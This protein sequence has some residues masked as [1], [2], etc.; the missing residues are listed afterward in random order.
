MSNRDLDEL[1]RELDR[2]MQEQLESLKKRTFGGIGDDEV[3]RE[4]ERLKRIREVS[5]DYLGALKR[6]TEKRRSD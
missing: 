4:E 2:L 1:R 3:R 6:E 5:A